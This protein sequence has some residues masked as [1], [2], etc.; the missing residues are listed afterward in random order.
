MD[1]TQEE[2]EN[3]IATTEEVISDYGQSMNKLIPLLQRLQDKL[4]YL[5]GLAMG[6]IAQAMEI[7]SVDVYEL[8]TFYNQF[9]LHPPGEHQIHVC[10]GTA[11]YM[12]GGQIA[13]DSFQRRLNIKEGETTPDRK[14]SLERVACVGCCSLAPVVVV[15]GQVEKNVTPTRVDGILMDYQEGN[16]AQDKISGI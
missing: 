7:P 1:L 6:K 8:A 15:D 16:E 5:P 13:M 10:M 14:Y 9:R 2:K 4:G 12:V 3:T 11:C